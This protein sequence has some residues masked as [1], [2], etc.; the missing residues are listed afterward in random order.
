MKR[1]LLD[2]LNVLFWIFKSLTSDNIG[3]PQP[4]NS[5][6]PLVLAV[7]SVT[8]SY[9]SLF[10]LLLA[11]YSLTTSY[12]FA[13]SAVAGC[14]FCTQILWICCFRC[15]WLYFL[16]P[17]SMNSLF[18]LLLAVYSALRCY[19]F[20]VS[21]VAGYVLSIY[22]LWIRRFRC[23]WLCFKHLHSAVAGRV[24]SN[25]ILHRLYDTFILIVSKALSRE[26]S[27]FFTF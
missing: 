18:S 10:P 27:C 21:A 14:I 8:T 7:Y 22:N 2:V 17:Q 6:F 12:E 23:C 9:D 3:E 11:V 25:Y 1:T 5:L 24:L 13:V 16:H 4:M 20:A 19:E 26:A 15:C